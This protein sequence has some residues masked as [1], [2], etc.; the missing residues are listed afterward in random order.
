MLIRNGADISIKNKKGRL[1]DDKYMG[2]ELELLQ[3]FAELKH[4]EIH[5]FYLNKRL[6][7][8]IVQF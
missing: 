4:G 7:D 5:L 3:F 6:N 1:P 8:C 2:Y